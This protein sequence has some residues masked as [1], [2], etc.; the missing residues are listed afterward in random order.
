MF[1][2]PAAIV[3]I[4]ACEHMRVMNRPREW[5]IF[6]EDWGSKKKMIEVPKED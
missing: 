6:Q 1:E 2:F 5:C 3:K 4:I